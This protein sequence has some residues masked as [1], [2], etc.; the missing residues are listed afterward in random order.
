M[1]TEINE[2]FLGAAFP[3]HTLDSL[4]V[5]HVTSRSGTVSK[6]AVKEPII[7]RN[8]DY[9]AMESGQTMQ[10]HS[11]VCYANKIN[12]FYT[13]LYLYGVCSALSYA[14]AAQL[15]IKPTSY[16]SFKLTR[17]YSPFE[18]SRL[19]MY[20]LARFPFY[21]TLLFNSTCPL[22][23]RSCRRPIL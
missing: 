7:L 22:C 10:S 14:I 20:L 13:A 3:T 23:V 12:P 19:L 16:K 17:G 8:T 6:L 1:T 21:C 5:L 18:M 11:P 2:G 15:F 9:V 4:R